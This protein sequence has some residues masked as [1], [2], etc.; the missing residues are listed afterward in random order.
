MILIS[1]ALIDNPALVLFL[2]CRLKLVF[3]ITSIKKLNKCML[4]TN[5]HQD[6]QLLNWLVINNLQ[7]FW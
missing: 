4:A 3:M 6:V 1:L 2:I 5:R 7:R